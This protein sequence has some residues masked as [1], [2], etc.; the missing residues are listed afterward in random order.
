M[1]NLN[2]II[3]NVSEL[4]L[5]NFTDVLESSAASLRKSVG[6]VPNAAVICVE[7]WHALLWQI[8]KG[9]QLFAE[10]FGSD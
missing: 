4:P 3:F 5:V 8:E 10:T 6:R 7:S 1:E 9:P 2:Y